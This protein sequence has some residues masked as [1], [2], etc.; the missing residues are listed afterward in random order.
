[1]IV[2]GFFIA[3]TIVCALT[4]VLGIVAAVIRDHP[5][6]YA[7]VSLGLVELFLVVY[8]VAAAVRQAGGEAIAGEAWEFWGYI[9]TALLIPVIAFWWA[10]SDK[11][12]WSNVVLAA[13]GATVFVMLFR[14]EQIWDGVLPA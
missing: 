14:M 7:I 2:D 5:D 10:V 12:R 4:V 3:G 9:A 11:T 6:D 8:A 13:A 1:M